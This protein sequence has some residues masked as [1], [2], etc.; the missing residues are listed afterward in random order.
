MDTLQLEYLFRRPHIVKN[1]MKGVFSR[2]NLP[3]QHTRPALYICNTDTTQYPGEHWVIF[4]FPKEYHEPIEYFDSYGRSPHI[5][6]EFVKFIGHN[7]FVYNDVLVQQPL[8][9][10]CGYH[11]FYYGFSRCIGESRLTVLKRYAENRMYNDDM[12]TKFTFKHI[13]N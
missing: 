1:T 4:F 13:Y 12:V 3:T 8:A 11:V 10:T 6:P 2:D 9:I 7:N 5:Y